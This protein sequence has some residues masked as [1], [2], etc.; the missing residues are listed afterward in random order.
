VRPKLV[1][2]LTIVS[3]VIVNQVYWYAVQNFKPLVTLGVTDYA[4]VGGDYP[5]F[6]NIIDLPRQFEEH[7]SHF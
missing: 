5:A 4:L 7:L 3:C 6:E 1:R 2:S